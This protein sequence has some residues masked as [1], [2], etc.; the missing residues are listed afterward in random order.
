M[1]CLIIG[2]LLDIYRYLECLWFW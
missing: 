1:L 2:N